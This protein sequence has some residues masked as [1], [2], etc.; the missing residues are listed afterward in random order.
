MV[1]TDI[2]QQ[3]RLTDRYSIFID[4][5]YSFSL[6]SQKLLEQQLAKGQRIDK[7]QLKDLKKAAVNDKLYGLVLRYCTSRLHSQKEVETYLEHK[8]VDTKTQTEI[9]NRLKKLDLVNDT[10][11]AQ[12]WINS[13]R[14]RSYSQRRIIQ[15]L[16][17]K[18][19]DNDIITKAISVDDA[20]DSNAIIEIVRKKRQQ[21]KYANDDL[22]LMRYLA[23]KGFNYANIKKIV[24]GD[25]DSD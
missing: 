7:L 20:S 9:I 24:K 21:A 25:K 5:R 4:G 1:I 19:I 14:Q 2:K 13:R 11:F 15:E 22:K 18:G 10:A 17:Q 6:S 12:A 23:Q 16:R 3:L 8:T